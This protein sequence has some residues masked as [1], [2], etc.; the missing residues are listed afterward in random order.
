MMAMPNHKIR[1]LMHR[2]KH[3]NQFAEKK[4]VNCMLLTAFIFA[5]GLGSLES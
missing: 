4:A 5:Y 2:A 1:R 3:N